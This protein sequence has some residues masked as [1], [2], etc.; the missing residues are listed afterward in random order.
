MLYMISYDL[1]TPGKD[2]SA[3]YDAIK[4]LG[5]WWHYLDSTWIIQSRHQVAD[6]SALIRQSIDAND[7]LIV[8]AIDSEKM[9][10]WLPQ[11]AWNWIRR[12]GKTH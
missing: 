9:D 2:Y 11:E 8:V 7:R 5:A 10:G 12:N 4:R 3:L 6:V 1:K